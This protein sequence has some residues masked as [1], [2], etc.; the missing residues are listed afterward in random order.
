M[1][2]QPLRR[3]IKRLFLKLGVYGVFWKIRGHLRGWRPTTLLANRRWRREHPDALPMPP[4]RLINDV[5]N[6]Y[7]IATFI[8]TGRHTADKIS[9]ALADAGLPL[10]RFTSVLDF[11]CGCGRVIRHWRDNTHASWHGCDY[12][13]TLVE[14]C[15]HNLDFAEFFVNALA[16]P[17]ECDDAAFDLIYA[18][19]V[20]THLDEDLQNRWLAELRRLL[21][22]GG[23]L[24]MTTHGDAWREGLD[25]AERALYDAGRIVVR[26]A[27]S[28]GSNLCETY[29][30]PAYFKAVA[31]RTFANVH[32]LPKGRPADKEQ[33]VWVLQVAAE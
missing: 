17:L 31:E 18:N 16:P 23:V 28:S 24:L 11:G 26:S 9:G 10:E 33:D 21:M 15:R 19:S 14:W 29:H 13:P 4:P 27:A 1:A 12:N 22:P 20:F 6:E 3:V 5:I 32:H 8:A 30:A 7:E 25:R 2:R